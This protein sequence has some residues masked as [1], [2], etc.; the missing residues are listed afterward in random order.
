MI[1][2]LT[3]KERLTG[4]IE[5]P[6]DHLKYRR[7]LIQLIN[8]QECQMQFIKS[9]MDGNFDDAIYFLNISEEILN[10]D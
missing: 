5:I 6:D 4:E 8:Y 7:K 10:D 3:L 9:H 2:K 1:I